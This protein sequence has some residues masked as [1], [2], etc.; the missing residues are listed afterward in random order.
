MATKDQEQKESVTA[1][2]EDKN[3][4][5]RL[6]R[7]QKNLQIIKELMSMNGRALISKKAHTTRH[8]ARP[9]QGMHEYI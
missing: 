4:R 1:A 9:R 7:Q 6:E 5:E 2:D 3:E 8:E